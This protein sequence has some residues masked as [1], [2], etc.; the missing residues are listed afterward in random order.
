LPT[1]LHLL[2]GDY[3]VVER[4]VDG[5]TLLMEK[6]ERVRLIGVDSPEN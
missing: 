2:T 1:A 6:G 3:R 4:V 5:D